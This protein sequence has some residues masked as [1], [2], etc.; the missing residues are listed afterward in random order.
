[1]S[2]YP[3]FR[4]YSEARVDAKLR[5]LSADE[6]RVWFNLLCLASETGD[7]RG[8]VDM[9][10]PFTLSLNVKFHIRCF[11]QEAA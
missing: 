4:M 6:F 2:R 9:S 11:H 10:D 5:S 8:T 1:M 7:G 3:W